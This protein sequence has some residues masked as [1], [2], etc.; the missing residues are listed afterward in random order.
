MML[1]LLEAFLVL[2]FEA[3]A[4]EALSST[5][6]QILSNS[7]HGYLSPIRYIH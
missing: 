5:P 2:L 6:M 3:T 4:D 7:L 1:V